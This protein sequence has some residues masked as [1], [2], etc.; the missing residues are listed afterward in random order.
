MAHAASFLRRNKTQPP[1]P[2]KGHA[3]TCQVYDVLADERL[4]ETRKDADVAR[5]LAL[6]QDALG[7]RVQLAAEVDGVDAGAWCATSP[8]RLRSP[9]DEPAAPGRQPR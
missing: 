5:L 7:I 9:E 1:F 6:L 8:A 2:L 4:T 3:L